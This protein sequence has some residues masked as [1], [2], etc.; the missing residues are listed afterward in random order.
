MWSAAQL[1]RAIGAYEFDRQ[2][3]ALT[4][5]E[6]KFRVGQAVHFYPKKPQSA[7]HGTYIVMAELPE[8]D[9]EFHY[10]IKSISEPHDRIAKESELRR[11]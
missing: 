9:G 8:R 3:M 6:H 7:P 2:A 11:E 4:M 5:S 1:E 10:R